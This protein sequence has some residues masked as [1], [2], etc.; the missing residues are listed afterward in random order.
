MIEFLTPVTKQI[1]AHR[2]VLPDGVIGKSIDMY[3]DAEE[4]PDLTGVTFAILG[5]AER[6]NDVD[7]I[8]ES[9]NFE[10]IRKAFYQLYPGNWGTKIVDLGDIQPGAAVTDTYFAVKSVVAQLV[11]LKIIPIILG[12][13]QDLAYAQYRSYD[14]FGR[15]VNLVNVDQRFD[16]GNAEKPITNKS[17]VGKIIV[18]QPYNLFNY[19][20]L[21]YQSYLNPPAEIALMDKLHFDAIR[22]GQLIGDIKEIE[23]MMRDAD[24]VTMDVTAI[25]GPELSYKYKDSP[26]GF[27][28]REVC[29]IARYAG[30]SNKVTSF[31]LYELKDFD[32][33]SNGAS[34]IGQ[35]LWYFIEGVNFRFDEGDLDDQ[36]M[37][38][39]YKVPIND[40][41]L[42]F[43][44]SNRSGRWWIELPIISSVNN[45]LKTQTLLPCTYGEYLG[46]TN[47]EIPE[48][49]FKA[50]QKL[51]V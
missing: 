13:S 30:I 18:D 37:Y 43:R 33:A 28:S 49:W 31:G 23:P 50:R 5:V 35:I 38:T 14:D 3:Q 24:L 25:K 42:L 12:G 19:S 10:A 27:D 2:E 6:R 51:E 9:I 40:E 26:N 36:R 8:G 1:V 44:K 29:A 34:L 22:L 20:V 17:Y 11:G 15:M 16:L 46:A 47:Q 48:R 41:V 21:G 39:L 7:Y 32:E 4:L 45:K